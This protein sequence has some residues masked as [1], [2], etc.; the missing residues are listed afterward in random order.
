VAVSRVYLSAAHQQHQ[1]QQRGVKRGI[2]AI[3]AAKS[4][5]IGGV[6]SGDEGG[7]TLGSDNNMAAQQ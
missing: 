6:K 7:R 4:A 2:S 5:G 1:H 3:G